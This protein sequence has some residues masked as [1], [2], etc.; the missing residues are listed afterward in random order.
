MTIQQHASFDSSAAEL[1]ATS[2]LVKAWESKNAK[3][4]AKAG[5][6]SLMALSLVACGGSS[7]TTTTPVVDAPVVDTPVVDTPVVDTPVVPAANAIALDG[8]TAAVSGTSGVDEI[9]GAVSALSSSNTLNAGAVID[10][11]LGDDVLKLAMSSDF[12]GFTT[13]VGSMTGIETIELTNSGSASRD[14]DGSGVSGVETYNISGNVTLT[15]IADLANIVI[16]DIATA[17]TVS[18][19]YAAATKVGTADEISL[20]LNGIG[21]ANSAASTV[22]ANT[23]YVDFTATG[24]ET[25]N[26]ASNAAAAAATA[27]GAGGNYV[28][29]AGSTNAGKIV[30]TG[31]NGLT[32]QDTGTS[33]TSFDASDATGDISANLTAAAADALSVVKTGSGD[34]S[35]TVAQLDL[36][37]NGA[38]DMGLGDDTL[39][40]SGA[41]E[42][43]AI[44]FSGIETLNVTAV[45]GSN[46]L[47]SVAGSDA[48]STIKA[49]EGENNDNTFASSAGVELIGDTGAKTLQFVGDQDGVLKTDTTG[50]V[51]IDVDGTAEALSTASEVSA[52]DLTLSKTT[53][54]DLDVANYVDY[55]GVIVAAKATDITVNNGATTNEFN[56]QAATL[57]DLTITSAGVMTVA[58]AAAIDNV[59]NLTV[60]ASK[61]VDLSNEGTMDHMSSAVLSGS[62]STSAT[63]LGALGSSTLSYDLDVT[64][65]GLKA[66]LVISTIDAGTENLTIDASATTGS[67]GLG[68]L[69]AGKVVTVN[70]D[71]A[72]G[73]VT[74]GNITAGSFVLN[75]AGAVGGV[76][77]GTSTSD[78]TIDS[79][80]TI[81]GPSLTALDTQLVTSADSG[82]VTVTTTGGIANDEV[83]VTANAATTSLT[84]SGDLG[85]GSS[86]D[87]IVTLADST[88]G[89]AVDVSGAVAELVT[90]NLAADVQAVSVTGSTSS[91]VSDVAFI[92]AMTTSALTLTSVD[93]LSVDGTTSVVNASSISGQTITVNGVATSDAITFS[94]TDAADTIDMSGVTADGGNVAL[95]TIDGGLAADTITGSVFQDTVIG[96]AGADVIDITEASATIDTIK[97]EATTYTDATAGDAT[98]GFNEEAGDLI[99]GFGS[100]DVLAFAEAALMGAGNSASIGNGT[101]GYETMTASADITADVTHVVWEVT[102]TGDISGTVDAD[103]VAALLTGASLVST[104]E[105][106]IVVDDGTDSYVFAWD[107]DIAASDDVTVDAT[108][109]TLVATIY[110]DAA[111]GAANFDVY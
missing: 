18:V 10:G 78:V 71:G 103:A 29:L 43:A 100:T 101:N 11:A 47:L 48:F 33:L 40:L 49:V 79:S 111:L 19:A 4:A 34:D 93:I 105:Y 91:S 97:F 25:L 54:I 83:T 31:T 17:S 82:A 46:T 9:S 15:D 89:I 85:V 84:V 8:T 12:G 67:V 21:A 96:A 13:N 74:T 60:S 109:L 104:G 38:I 53:K 20:T 55:N 24:I 27:S 62:A 108:E 41:G 76:T 56:I 6:V 75:A 70:V 61:S 90:V 45:T 16:S 50:N 32:V 88:A 110:G 39:S 92:N 80:A 99:T 102:G 69:D 66:G 22:A 98:V 81:T 3:N 68:T 52:T 28:S 37:A 64:A 57:T 5:G 65:T 106:M 44:T 107:G 63:T 58:S 86:D 95:F 42:T 59:Q 26:I 36:L 1:N 77:L 23:K 94:G 14:F 30:V 51:S 72:L 87:Y 2:K 35:L 73:A 7:T